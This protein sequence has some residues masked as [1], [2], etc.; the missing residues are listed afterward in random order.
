MGCNERRD[1]ENEIDA[2]TDNSYCGEPYVQFLHLV[3]QTKL[4]DIIF[5]HA[6]ATLCLASLAYMGWVDGAGGVAELIDLSLPIALDSHNQVT[7]CASNNSASTWFRR[8][9]KP[10]NGGRAP[11][12][13]FDVH[14]FELF[15]WCPKCSSQTVKMPKFA[16]LRQGQTACSSSTKTTWSSECI[17]VET[18]NYSGY[19]HPGVAKNGTHC[20]RGMIS[21]NIE[22]LE[23]ERCSL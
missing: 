18:C 21:G 22:A 16:L 17:C 8:P 9:K 3:S 10:K 2:R 19:R 11:C 20:S 6:N 13:L 7:H 14:L 5:F 23:M 12:L 15:G 1:A 4:R